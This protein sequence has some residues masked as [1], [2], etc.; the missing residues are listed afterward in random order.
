MG[1]EAGQITVSTDAS[2]AFSVSGRLTTPEGQGLRN[3]VVRLTAADG[4]IRSVTTSSFGNYMF[5]NVAA[6]AGYTLTVSSRRYRFAA[7]PISV[8][9]TL[10]GIDL[11]G[12]K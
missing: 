7:R 9:R 1:F 3:A 6:G 2:A 12:L 5:E 10:T 11:T 8:T 4:S